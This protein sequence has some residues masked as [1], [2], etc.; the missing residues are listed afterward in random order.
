MKLFI[1]SA[2][3]FSICVT[4]VTLAGINSFFF[5]MFIKYYDYSVEAFISLPVYKYR[6]SAD[7]ERNGLQM[8]SSTICKDQQTLNGYCLTWYAN[9]DENYLSMQA[10]L[11]QFSHFIPFFFFFF[12]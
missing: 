2:S 6:L 8:M 1:L 3:Y 12:F 5:N 10:D 9:S 4:V 11:D 7:H